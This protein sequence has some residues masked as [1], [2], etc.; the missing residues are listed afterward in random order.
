MLTSN[1]ILSIP[2][3]FM[4]DIPIHGIRGE[5]FPWLGL[6]KFLVNFEN[7]SPPFSIWGSRPPAI[8]AQICRLY[9]IR[10]SRRYEHNLDCCIS[11]SET[12][13]RLRFTATVD[14]ITI[15]FSVEDLHGSCKLC[16]VKAISSW[17]TGCTIWHIERG[18]HEV[19]RFF[20]SQL[21]TRWAVL[22]SS[23]SCLNLL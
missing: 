4:G 13:K 10:A 8:F 18:Q 7:V 1:F 12:S 15:S 5:I 23:T 9:G 2:A 6:L 11:Y 20:H 14:K 17:V 21:A 16:Y 19:E 3:E 22:F